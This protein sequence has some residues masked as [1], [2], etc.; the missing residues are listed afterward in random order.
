MYI[1]IQFFFLK[2]KF[3]YYSWEAL[4]PPHL[5]SMFPDT[6][7]KQKQATTPDQ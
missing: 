7:K 2:L 1:V 4:G 5:V 6:N 3:L